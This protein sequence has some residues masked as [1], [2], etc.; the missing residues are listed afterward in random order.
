MRR[1]FNPSHSHV[2]CCSYHF[3]HPPSSSRHTCCFPTQSTPLDSACLH[4][5]KFFA[6]S[7]RWCARSGTTCDTCLYYRGRLH[8]D[9]QTREKTH[10][11]THTN[12]DHQS[13]IVVCLAAPSRSKEKIQTKMKYAL[14]FLTCKLPRV[15]KAFPNIACLTLCVCVCIVLHWENST[16]GHRYNQSLDCRSGSCTKG[17]IHLNPTAAGK[18]GERDETRE[19]WAKRGRMRENGEAGQVRGKVKERHWE[20]KGH[21]QNK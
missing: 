1:K 12:Q 5:N 13:S 20:Q 3:F 2:G 15:P 17:T 7:K 21:Q 10:T 16:A 6:Y 4:N 14:V 9:T 8:R 19:R 11:Y 18:C